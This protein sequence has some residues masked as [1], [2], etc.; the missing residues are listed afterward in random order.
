MTG[1]LKRFLT[2]PVLYLSHLHIIIKW[3]SASLSG[4]LLRLVYVLRR[5]AESKKIES[6]HAKLESFSVLY[7]GPRS[8]PLESR[9]YRFVHGQMGTFDLFI[10]PVGDR[11]KEITYEAG[12]NR[13][14]M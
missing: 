8:K 10:S 5:D 2:P 14:Q 6:R 13:F 9:I 1:S 11:E 4:V 3:G 7:R 12:F